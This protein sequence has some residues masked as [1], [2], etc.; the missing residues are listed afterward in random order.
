M[1]ELTS[2]VPQIAIWAGMIRSVRCESVLATVQNLV[3]DVSIVIYLQYYC[4]DIAC[5]FIFSFARAHLICL[6]VNEVRFY[7][8]DFIMLFTSGAPEKANCFAPF[9]VEVGKATRVFPEG[10]VALQ[11]EPTFTVDIKFSCQT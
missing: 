1:Q 6:P 9:R 11:P 4:C 3:L 2:H 8:K 7:Y 10:D 5:W